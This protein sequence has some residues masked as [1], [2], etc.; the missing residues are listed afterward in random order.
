MQA[1][2]RMQQRAM[3]AS[4]TTAMKQFTF[5]PQMMSMGIQRMQFSSDI[6]RVN[7]GANLLRKAV[8]KEIK[9]ES[10]NYTQLED[11]ETFLNE[12][13]F[14]FNEEGNG[15]KMTLVKSVGDKQIE[16]HFEAR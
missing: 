4:K 11:I 2:K 13:G 9:F 3:M 6:S 7:K 12:S 14:A 1:V 5:A 15:I 16:V 8:E 10:E